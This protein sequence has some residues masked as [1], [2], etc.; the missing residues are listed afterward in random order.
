MNAPILKLFGLFLVLF[1]ALAGMTSYN[2]VINADAYRE[3]DKNSRP[4]IE[5]QR[6]HRGVIRAD[7]GTLLAR[8]LERPDGSF[9]RTYPLPK[10]FPHA[11][12]Y[13]FINRSRAGL[14]RSYNDDLSGSK[15]ELGGIIDRLA[16]TRREGDDLITSLDPAAQRVAEQQLGDR[17][18]AVVAL[19]PR[20]GA[21]KVMV[22]IPGYDPNDIPQSY[23][24][25]NRDQSA[26]L[27][28]RATQSG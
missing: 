27:F 14:E 5:E 25:L 4:Q 21:I 7:D 13:N 20:T 8:S 12:G 26:P 24:E 9:V 6:I 22:S 10:L 17:K 15:N 18:G 23:G 1:A 16:G 11:V 19:D 3:N 2:S 28:N